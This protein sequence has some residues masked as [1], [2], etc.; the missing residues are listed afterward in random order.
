MLLLR[1]DPF[2]RH[3]RT[4]HG[5]LDLCNYA[6]CTSTLQQNALSQAPPQC[7]NVNLH[8]S[9]DPKSTHKLAQRPV[10]EALNCLCAGSC[11]CNEANLSGEA[12]PVQKRQCPA[13]DIRYDVEGKGARHTLF[14]ST[15]VLQAGTNHSDEV[16][17]V[18]SATG[19]LP[20]CKV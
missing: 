6:S 13:E 5:R 4:Y 8:V 7:Q 20:C 10:Y 3:L 2:A 12:M 1:C 16:L 9:F 11:V 15:T 14:S 17:A 18:V 19:R